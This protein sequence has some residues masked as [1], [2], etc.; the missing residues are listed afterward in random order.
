M[1]VRAGL[2][3]ARAQGRRGGRPPKL[4]ALQQ[5]EILAMVLAGRKTAAA[6]ARLFGVHP[7]TVCR[8]VAAARQQGP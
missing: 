5:E 7:S 2:S 6:A 4:P 1:R 3:A 8:L